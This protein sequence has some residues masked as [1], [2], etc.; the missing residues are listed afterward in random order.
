M[1]ITVMLQGDSRSVLT[2]LALPYE[3]SQSCSVLD[4]TC[5]TNIMWSN[6]HN[7]TSSSHGLTISIKTNQNIYQQQ[8]VKNTI[9]GG[10]QYSTQTQS[11]SQE[12]NNK[13]SPYPQESS[14]GT[15]ISIELWLLFTII[16]LY[17][18]P[19]RCP[20]KNA[21]VLLQLATWAFLIALYFWV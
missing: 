13:C 15:L 3:C 1:E 18:N 21:P 12:K 7:V 2:G 10:R 17:D 8:T 6:H 20:N 16:Q 14:H 9:H 4:M 19:T 5:V 11:S